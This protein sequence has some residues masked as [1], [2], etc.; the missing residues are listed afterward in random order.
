MLVDREG[1]PVRVETKDLDEANDHH[2]EPG[3]LAQLARHR[4]LERLAGFDVTAG[5]RPLPRTWGPGATDDEHA[6]I[7]AEDDGTDG[8]DLP[9]ASRSHRLIVSG[10]R[11]RGAEKDA[12][13]A[14]GHVFGLRRSVVVPTC[15]PDVV[16]G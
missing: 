12:R 14:R 4:G 7:A 6:P 15:A 8:N 9:F 5:E 2:V 13:G 3:L 11:R 16:P 10:P 1:S